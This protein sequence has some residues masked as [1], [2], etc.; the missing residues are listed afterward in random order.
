MVLVGAGDDDSW[1]EFCVLASRLVFPFGMAVGICPYFVLQEHDSEGHGDVRA[2]D[3]AIQPSVPYASH[4]WT[5]RTA[6][7]RA[8]A[9][10][11]AV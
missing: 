7:T 6:R 10:Y 8:F 9:S 5:G 2:M 3:C 11:V 4:L 1:S